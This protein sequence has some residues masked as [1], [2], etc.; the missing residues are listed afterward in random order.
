MN[1]C[2]KCF[3]DEYIKG[4]IKKQGEIGEC[5]CCGKKDKKIISTTVEELKDS[6]EALL[7]MYIPIEN[8][9]GYLSSDGELLKTII[10]NDWNIFNKKVPLPIIEKILRD[11][12]PEREELYSKKV[13]ILNSKEQ[14]K[15]SILKNS[16]WQEFVKEIK[17][18]NRFHT[19]IFSLENFS[20]FLPGLS[21]ELKKGKKLLRGRISTESGYNKD[22]MG[23]PPLEYATSG[24]INP[25]GI[26]S[27]YLAE[28]SETIFKEMRVLKNDFVTI[29]EF[30]LKED[31]TIVDLT[32]IDKLSPFFDLDQIL[33]Y[34]T[35]QKHLREI[36][37][38]ISRP[39]N[40]YNNS[41]DYLPSQY[42]AEYIKSSGFDGLKYNSTVKSGGINFA[43]F[44]K[45]KFECNEVKVHKITD[46]HCHSEN[47]EE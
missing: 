11:I 16:T 14:Q 3:S 26:S 44:S 45:E 33:R 47:V 38:E 5:S 8:I 2:E 27:L 18:V 40:R 4:V 19:E 39:Q 1:V 24:R 37:L 29:G 7:D 21:L 43:I 22:E 13:A 41:L 30:E 34:G 9:E 36:A 20:Y 17:G 15:I 25:E 46:I 10:K 28:D 31:I 32:R 35:N 42:I 6:F 12:L 23:A